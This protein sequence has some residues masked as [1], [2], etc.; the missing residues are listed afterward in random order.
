[1]LSEIYH[2]F[3]ELI[4]GKFLPCYVISREPL[5]IVVYWEDFVNCK[6][7]FL[8]S[9]PDDKNVYILCQLGWHYET[10]ER[11]KEAQT[12]NELFA[13]L[14]PNLKFIYLCNSAIE[15]NLFRK[16]E[17]NGILCHQNAFIDEKQYR[18]IKGAK[19]IYDAIYISRIT[20]F[21]RHLLAS[22]IKS[23]YLIGYCY[24]FEA[25]YRKTVFQAMPQALWK[26]KVYAFNIYK[27]ISKAHVGLCLSAEEGAMFVSAEYLLCGIPVVSTRNKGGRDVMFTPEHVF[28]AD[29]TPE[30]VAQG[31]TE[32]TQRHLLPT[33][34]RNAII[35]KMLNYREI[36][37]QIVQ[38]IYNA[39]KTGR[40]FRDE[41]PEVF[42]HKLGVRCRVSIWTKLRRGL[43]VKK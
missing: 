43:K 42:I 19:K 36:F 24:D 31:V 7:D 18:I 41:W 11:I 39:E 26:K 8:K 27:E 30:S 37:I 21:K 33:S 6:D 3:M 12:A 25:E 23:L 22:K 5:I 40:K 9:L 15:E 32:M 13:S 38:T 17:M 10:E 1:M 4:F 16:Y 34:I 2:K 35:A 29:D 28:I 20:P 14:H